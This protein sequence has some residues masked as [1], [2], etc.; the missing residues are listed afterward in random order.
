LG[1]RGRFRRCDLARRAAP[2]AAPGPDPPNMDRDT[3][4]PA[5][6]GNGYRRFGRNRAFRRRS[7]R[8]RQH[9]RDPGVDPA[10]G[11]GSRLGHAF[12]DKISERPQRCDRR[13]VDDGAGGRVLGAVAHGT[14]QR[15]RYSGEFRSLS[16]AAR[17]ANLVPA[18]RARLPLG[19]ANSRDAVA[20]FA[21]A[22][23]A[24]PGATRDTPVTRLRRAR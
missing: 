19:P 9:R 6:A 14:E 7:A 20:K 2:G 22:G 4:E 15:R 17:H 23:R 3:G 13:D 18:S 5:L 12:G 16:P 1:D 21:G 8:N 10:L 11:A 24:V